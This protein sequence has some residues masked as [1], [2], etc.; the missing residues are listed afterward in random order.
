MNTP[1]RFLLASTLAAGSSLITFAAPTEP[2][3]Q[4]GNLLTGTEGQ[5]QSR[6]IATSGTDAV[7]WMAHNGSTSA[8]RDIT[9]GGDFLYDGTEYEGTSANKNLTLLK[10]NA[11]GEEQ[12][13]IYS[14]SGDFI[15]NEGEIAVTKEGNL[16]IFG[17][18]RHTDLK[19]ENGISLIDTKG[20][21]TDLGWTVGDRRNVRLFLAT[22]TSTGEI[23]W[24]RT[25][26]ISTEPAPKAS[27]NNSDFTAGAVN[28]YALVV[29]DNNN[30]YIGGRYRNPLTFPKA[31]GTV[32]TL[33]PK[34]VSTWTGDAQATTG[35]LFV[36]KLDAEGNYLAHLAETG[37]EVGITYI[38]D[39]A[40]KDGYLYMAGYAK[41]EGTINL[42]GVSLT[43]NQY[44]GPIVAKL[45]TDLKPVWMEILPGDAVG[46][47]N[48]VQN[49][50][51]TVSKANVWLAGMYNGKI[52]SPDN[53][54]DYVSSTQ[55]NL[56]EG[57][58]IKLSA[59]DGSWLG[60]AN[61]RSEFDQ[62]YLTSYLKVID[63]D[64]TGSDEIMVYGYAM[65]ATVGVFLRSYNAETL[66]GNPDKSWNIITGG[67]APAAIDI[68]YVP[69]LATA[70]MTA[71]GNKAFTPMG[72]PAS[73]AI[74]GFTNYLSRFDLPTPVQ[75]SQVA[76]SDEEAPVEYYNLQGLRITDPIPGTPCIR[77]QGT[78]T[79]KILF[80]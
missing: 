64:A 40:M 44:V 12:W 67:G 16:V 23:L 39:L 65:N 15:T 31:D 62:N 59:E 10:T 79:D 53:E 48:A 76:I 45:D 41:G 13:V 72:G 33:T 77:R 29:D 5:D 2:E 9:Y 56:R 35:D 74:T 54:S 28:A 47:K 34:N 61:S 20:K 71:R 68:A 32:V 24:A 69:E 1:L 22:A 70:Y 55:G 78:R 57:F 36:V 51:M 14:G 75:T 18:V 21:K 73:D 60:G 49:I 58:I 3:F 11:A 6:G 26:E 7:Y 30:I 43:A 42:G 25:Y 52:S 8:D 17:A 46:G 38:W 66:E 27:G 19:Y 37:D 50:G 63:E 4:W 80:R